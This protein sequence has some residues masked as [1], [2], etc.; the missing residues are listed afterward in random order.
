MLEIRTLA[1]LDENAF[2]RIMLTGYTSTQKYAI[3]KSE[4]ERA[5]AITL[6]LVELDQP[7]AK[8]FSPT[9]EDVQHYHAVVKLGWSLGAFLDGY[10]VAVAIAEPRYWNHTLWVWEFH[11]E[12]AHR[13]HNVGRQLM[14]ALAERAREGGLRALIC[15]T[16]STNLP[17]IRFYRRVGFAIEGIDISYYTNQDYPDG[18]MAIF[19]KRRV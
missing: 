12:K 4:N 1:E 7:Y 11:V 17:A 15:E 18:E 14:D 13:G 3:H 6:E 8:D 10:M 19:M 9:E 16:Q 5:A 2:R